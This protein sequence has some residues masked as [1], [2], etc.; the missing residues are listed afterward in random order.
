MRSHP[1][2]SA[3]VSLGACRST[4]SSFR[5]HV[6]MLFALLVDGCKIG[7]VRATPAAIESQITRGGVKLGSDFCRVYARSFVPTTAGPET[8]S[9]ESQ[10]LLE[11]TKLGD[12]Y[13]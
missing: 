12:P 7:H 1:P 10:R 5:R 6:T 4:T 2:A 9:G 3:V 11:N 13:I 8:A